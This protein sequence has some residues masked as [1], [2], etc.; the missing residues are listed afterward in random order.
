[1]TF[2]NCLPRLMSATIGMHL[3]AMPAVI[4]TGARQTGKSTLAKQI[5][6]DSREFY[7]LDDFDTLHTAQQSPMAILGGRHS[8]TIDEIQRSPDL[9]IAVKRA[10]DQDRKAGRFPAHRFCESVTDAKCRR[11]SGWAR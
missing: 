11:V 7:S 5:A 10:I 9:L 1:M 3:K 2:E 8:I 4:L 6:N